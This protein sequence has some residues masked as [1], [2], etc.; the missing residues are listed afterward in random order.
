[1]SLLDRRLLEHDDA[2]GMT[3]W[4]HFDVHT[5]GFTV[6]TTQDTSLLLDSNL[7]QW[8]ATEKHTRY[9]DGLGG[10]VASIP[11]VVLMELSKQ[12]IVTPAGAVL[13]EPKFRRWLNDSDN[14]LFRTRAGTV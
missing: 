6:E 13:D 7:R 1:M 8:N 10:R 2:T 4:Y 12:G 3:E 5:G 11:N 9:G 14:R